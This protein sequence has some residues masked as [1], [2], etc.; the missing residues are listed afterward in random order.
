MET[1]TL[2][3]NILELNLTDDEHR[4][5]EEV[6]THHAD[7]VADKKTEILKWNSA[8]DKAY[9]IKL[10]QLRPEIVENPIRDYFN[11]RMETTKTNVELDELLFNVF[12]EGMQ[13]QKGR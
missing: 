12:R 2:N 3:Y 8:Y 13:Y 5:L 11:E 6:S 9:D 4:I 1:R 7:I 10:Q